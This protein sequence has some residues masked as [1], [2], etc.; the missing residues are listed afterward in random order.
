MGK[1]KKKSTKK[2]VTFLSFDSMPAH[3][4][5][6]SSLHLFLLS[7][8]SHSLIDLSVKLVHLNPHPYHFF[9]L[10]PTVRRMGEGH[11]LAV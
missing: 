2:K 10:Y 11:G 5:V 8:T 7:C 4:A 3:P 9:I 1:K 6:R